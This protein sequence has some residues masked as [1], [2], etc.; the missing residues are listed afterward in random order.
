MK[1]EGKKRVTL[2]WRNLTNTISSQV[3]K[4]DTLVSHDDNIH[5][6]YDV[7][8]MALYIRGLPPQNT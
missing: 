7:M 2:Q 6:W 1:R 4:F 5:L 3:I 8:R